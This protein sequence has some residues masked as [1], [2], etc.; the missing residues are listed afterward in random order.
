GV[1]DRLA[2][3]VPFPVLESIMQI[4]AA[5]ARVQGAPLSIEALDI[6]DPRDNEILVKVVAT[7][8]CHTDL[9]VRDGMLPTPLPVVLGH[10]GAGIVTKV[11]RAI[12]K[13]DVGD[14]VVMTFNS[15][16][17]CPSCQDH[18]VSYCHEFFPRNFF[19][20]RADGTSALSKQGRSEE[21]RVGRVGT[22]RWS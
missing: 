13:V 19:A 4:K 11:G 18:H 5:V 10:E 14:H 17:R 7:G 20:A 8:V 3:R 22:S 6:E 16:G 2:R 1:P 15:C 12:S 21:R 9:V